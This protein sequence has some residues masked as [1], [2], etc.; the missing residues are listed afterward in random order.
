MEDMRDGIFSRSFGGKLKRV[1]ESGI[2]ERM[3][4]FTSISKTFMTID[5]RATRR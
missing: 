5:V 1:Q 3:Q 4:F 2:E